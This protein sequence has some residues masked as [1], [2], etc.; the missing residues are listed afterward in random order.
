MYVYGWG[1]WK[2]ERGCSVGFTEAKGVALAFLEGVGGLI[3]IQVGS[4][5]GSSEGKWVVTRD[6]KRMRAFPW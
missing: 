3:Q 4:G 5:W 2:E 6:S 1:S